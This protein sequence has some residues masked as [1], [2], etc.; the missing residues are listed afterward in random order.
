MAESFEFKLTGSSPHT[1][2]TFLDWSD[3]DPVPRF[4]PTHVGNIMSGWICQA[5]QTVHP[6]TRGEHSANLS[7]T[8][9]RAGSSPHTWGTYKF[10]LS[11]GKF[12][13]FIPTHVGNILYEKILSSKKRG[14]SPHTWG[15][16]QGRLTDI[17]LLRFIP[18]HVGNIILY[19][20]VA[21]PK[22]VHPHTRGEHGCVFSF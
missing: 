11:N 5:P 19:F 1:W 21:I 13:R 10:L 8:A 15:T 20:S 6:H 12:Y 2:G 14:S 3:D 4:I 17:R 7:M 9:I 16:F 22:T 18:T